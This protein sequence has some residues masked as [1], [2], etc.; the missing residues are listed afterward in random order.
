MIREYGQYVLRLSFNVN[1]D[2]GSGL[3]FC[4]HYAI[5]TE[6][7]EVDKLSHK[8]SENRH[9]LKLLKCIQMWSSK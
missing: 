8:V 9:N 6:D 4:A 5:S 7:I 3:N 1:C 2:H